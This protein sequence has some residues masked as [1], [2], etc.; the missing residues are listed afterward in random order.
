MQ[1]EI[2]IDGKPWGAL[3]S[4]E[5]QR[6]NIEKVRSWHLFH[7]SS[8][9]MPPKIPVEWEINATFKDDRN[10]QAFFRD[11]FA[12]EITLTIE[13]HHPAGP[14]TWMICKNV[15]LNGELVDLTIKDEWRT[16]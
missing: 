12:S 6:E 7:E 15:S 11:I 3:K 14:V 8:D 16:V 4:I 10:I 1:G 13:P 5:F 9:I 2:T